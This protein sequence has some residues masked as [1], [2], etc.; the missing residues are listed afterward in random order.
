MY[1][2]VLCTYFLFKL[3]LNDSGEGMNG[4]FVPFGPM[5][6]VQLNILISINQ[7]NE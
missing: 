7:Q 1:K 4:L 5:I 2:I 3:G 6:N